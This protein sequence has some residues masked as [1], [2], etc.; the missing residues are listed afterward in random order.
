DGYARIVRLAADAGTPVIVDSHG[1]ALE[2]AIAAGPTIVKVN[3]AEAGA[4]TAA[5]ALPAARSIIERG[6]GAAV[7]TLGAEGAVLADGAGAWRLSAPPTTR[8]AYPVG[9]GDAFL[10]GLASGMVDGL[11]LVEA[12]RRGMAAGFA[13]A[14]RPG[15][16]NL[17]PAPASMAFDQIVATPIAE[18]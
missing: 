17:D 15:A 6:A 7:I 13:N 11:T 2:L 5:D 16:G 9:S 12:A 8:G 1:P 3:A 10:A 4:A 14:Q 18:S